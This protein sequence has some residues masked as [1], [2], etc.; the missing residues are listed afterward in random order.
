M[1]LLGKLT[2]AAIPWDSPLP[3]YASAVAALAIVGTL[4]WVLCERPLPVSLAGVA[5]ERR[6]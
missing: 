3:L 2:W 6:S 5:D 1:N 4:G